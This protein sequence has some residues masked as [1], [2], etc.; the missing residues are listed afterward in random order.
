MVLSDIGDDC[1][2][3]AAALIGFVYVHW[4]VASWLD[5]WV[6]SFSKFF[7]TYVIYLRGW[8]D[9]FCTITIHK[10]KIGEWDSME[11]ICGLDLL[12]SCSLWTCHVFCCW[13]L[14]FPF[15]LP[16]MRKDY[17]TVLARICNNGFPHIIPVLLNDTLLLGFFLFL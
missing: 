6:S 9:D 15:K 1:T 10:A 7:G 16:L 13:I 17:G 11:E 12:V 14:F 4:N 2:I 8:H 3:L 5:L